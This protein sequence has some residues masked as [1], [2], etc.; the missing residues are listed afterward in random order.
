[1]GVDAVSLSLLLQAQGV[2]ISWEEGPCHLSR[3][4][5]TSIYMSSHVC[6]HRYMCTGMSACGSLKLMPGVFLL[7]WVKRSVLPNPELIFW[8]H[9]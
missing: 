6:M 3:S 9:S 1:M 4:P 2:S 7:S 5:C 8:E